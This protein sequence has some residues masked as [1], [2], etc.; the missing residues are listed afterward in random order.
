MESL[1]FPV[2]VTAI[3][4]LVPGCKSR[5][6]GPYVSPRIEGVVVAADTG[7]PLAR[8]AVVRSGDVSGSPREP[9]KGGELLARPAPVLTDSD[10]RFAL[11]SQRVL[12]L[13]RGAGWNQAWLTFSRAG[14]L[15]LETN[16]SLAA[17]TN[18]PKGGPLV[19][20]GP[21]SLVPAR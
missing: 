16:F 17:A 14:Y 10:G 15:K 1:R 11:S 5:P 9:L 19:D 3:A 4:I 20:V 8:V 2:L 12:T 13:F 7:E 21:V 6:M 18:S